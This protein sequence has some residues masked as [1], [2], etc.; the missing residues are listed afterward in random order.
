M[1]A[2]VEGKTKVIR[3]GPGEDTIILETKDL[4]TGGDAARRESI[5]AIGIDKRHKPP[6]FS[7]YCSVTASRLPSLSA[8]PRASYSV[9]AVTC[10]RWNW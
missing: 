1:P 5:A 6:M 2:I 3:C 9:I 10:F 4:L 8:P 7:R